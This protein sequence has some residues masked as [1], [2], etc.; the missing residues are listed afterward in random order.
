MRTQDMSDSVYIS[1]V[2]MSGYFPLS[3]TVPAAERETP[4]AKAYVMCRFRWKSVKRFLRCKNAPQN[5]P[6]RRDV[7]AL[8]PA[9]E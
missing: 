5:C 2:S 3:E 8:A 6:V 7:T 1:A 9:V 4:A